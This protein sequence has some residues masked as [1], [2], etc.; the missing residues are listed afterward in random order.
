MGAALRRHKGYPNGLAGFFKSDGQ[1]WAGDHEEW[2]I[3]SFYGF[4]TS[5]GA[6]A[7]AAI[8]GKFQQAL[9]LLRH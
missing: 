8:A 1:R 6:A 4:S 5:T 2:G 7:I 9:A 3:L